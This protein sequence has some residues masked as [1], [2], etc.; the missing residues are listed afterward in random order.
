[1][2]YAAFERKLK[3]RNVT[4]EAVLA[5][6]AAARRAPCVARVWGYLGF[7]LQKSDITLSSLRPAPQM[8]R[9]VSFSLLKGKRSPL[10]GSSPRLFSRVRDARGLGEVLLVLCPPLFW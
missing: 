8:D 7:R 4:E 10:L 5:A 9:P 1:M 3:R 2:D 6:Q